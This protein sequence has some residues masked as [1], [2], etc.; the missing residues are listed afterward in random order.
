MSLY[1]VSKEKRMRIKPW[2]ML[3]FMYRK[4]NY[5]WEGNII[6]IKDNIISQKLK[7]R[8]AVIYVKGSEKRPGGVRA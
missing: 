8:E 3:I 7:E 5:T 4:E 6:V 1:D 2:R